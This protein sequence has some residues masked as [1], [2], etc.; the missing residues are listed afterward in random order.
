MSALNTHFAYLNR[1]THCKHVSSELHIC[2]RCKFETYCSVECQKYDWRKHKKECVKSENDEIIVGRNVI[3]NIMDLPQFLEYTI[4]LCKDW[5]H[6]REFCLMAVVTKSKDQSLPTK[7]RAINGDIPHLYDVKFTR[8]DIENDHFDDELKI[9]LVY[10]SDVTKKSEFMC[11]FYINKTQTNKLASANYMNTQ[12]GLLKT[13]NV[14]LANY[15]EKG[16]VIQ[17]V[18]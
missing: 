12:P 6:Q 2:S 3:K 5:A 1:C 4:R 14:N 16:F 9:I 7:L 11:N 13:K 8:E 10:V 18:L 15:I 17:V